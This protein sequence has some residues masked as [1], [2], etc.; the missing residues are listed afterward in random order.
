[1]TVHIRAFRRGQQGVVLFIALIV[2][3]A[4]SLAGLGLMRSVD[5]GTLVASNLAFKQGAMHGGDRGIEAAR[6][7]LLA[8]SSG[9]SLDN[10]R[11]SDAY[12]AT[13]QSSLDLLG[14]DP[15]KADLDW[16]AAAKDMGTDAAGNRAQYVIHRMCETVGAVA[17]INCVRVASTDGLSAKKSGVHYGSYGIESKASVY[18][19]VTVKVTGPRNTVTYIQA[20]MY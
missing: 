5:T 1:M 3:V 9:S 19:R 16:N 12:Y 20:T 6:G 14:N 4:M 10:D 8:N 11:P 2:L 18:Y 7:W 17:G 15:S 13:T